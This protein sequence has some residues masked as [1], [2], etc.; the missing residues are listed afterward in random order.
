VPLVHA[1]W[2]VPVLGLGNTVGLTCAGIALFVAVRASRG[3]AALLGSGRAA[4]AGL[5]G[6][7][8]G[9]G[10]GVLVSAGLQVTGFFPNAFV[11]LLACASAAIAFGV[12][13]LVLDGRDLRAILGRT[14]GRR[15]R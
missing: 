11:A 14:V 6:A 1:R 8:A 7:V 5:A 13:V 12:A 9:A 3:P 2:V 15:F 4:A 10:A